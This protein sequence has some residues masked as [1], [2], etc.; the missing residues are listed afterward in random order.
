[1]EQ[2]NNRDLHLPVKGGGAWVTHCEGKSKEFSTK[3]EKNSRA[4]KEYDE[5]MGNI[6][7][8]KQCVSEK[9]HSWD[10]GG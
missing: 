3:K 9:L 2:T 5:S 7:R 10:P 1:M 4:R 6:S 8:S